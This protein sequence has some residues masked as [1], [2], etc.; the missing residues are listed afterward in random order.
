MEKKGESKDKK[1]DKKPE[2]VEEKKEEKFD[3]YLGNPPPLTIFIPLF[4]I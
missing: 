3:P 1:V 4:I 2:K